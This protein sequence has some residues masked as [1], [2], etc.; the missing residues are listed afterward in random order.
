MQDKPKK[1]STD[2]GYYVL[3]V[4]IMLDMGFSIAVPAVAAALLGQYLDEKYD[5][6]PLF[7]ILLL[8]N[9]FL[10]SARIIITKAK[11]YGKEYENLDK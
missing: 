10:I 2:H 7:I 6:A 4:K 1:Q 11:R 5:R 9:A 3:G 8:V